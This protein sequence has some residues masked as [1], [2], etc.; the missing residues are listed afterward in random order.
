MSTYNPKRS[1]R[2]VRLVVALVLAATAAG[3]VYLYA[4]SMQR[5]VTQQQARPQPDASVAPTENPPVPVISVVVAHTDLQAKTPLG[6]DAFEL[7]EVPADRVATNAVKSL[8]AVSG[9]MLNAPLAAGEP[10][11][12]S[13]LVDSKSADIKTIADMIPTG[14][15]AMSLTLT[16]LDG[17]GGLIVPGQ[18]VD[19]VAVFTKD[20]LG[21][22]Q[23]MIM[24]QDI[25]VLAVAQSTSADQLVPVI[26]P[27]AAAARGNTRAAAPAAAA[28]P[29]LGATTRATPIPAA[30]AT[31]TQVAD[32]SA[33]APTDRLPAAPLQAKTVTVAVAPEAVERLALAK[34]HGHLSYVIR[35]TSERTQQS[36]LPADLG[37]LASPL[38]AAAAE[39]L[40][41]E[42]SPTN[43]KVGDTLTVK[44][45]IKNT[46]DKPLQ[47]MGPAPGFTYVQGQT[48]YTQQFASQP[49]KWRVAIGSAGLDSTELPYRWGLGADLA[50][51]AS[52]TVTGQIKLTAD[53]R[54]TNFWAAIVSE[55]AK[56]V[57]N[58]VGITLITAMPEN[59]AV[60]TVDSANARS[61]PSIA[62]SVI[63]QVP[64]GTELEIVGQSADWFK[65]KLPD[66]RVAWMAAGWIVVP[67]R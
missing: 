41:T 31:P 18:H 48:Y 19:V 30:T 51:G 49:G 37:T 5:Q 3:G 66:Q 4:S 9:K 11:T 32:S 67:G 50:P 60:V 27:T 16:E 56:I 1:R 40:A 63:D 58:G 21:K 44:I 36:L 8:E 25:L 2:G 65:V 39:I 46:S 26:T 20:T 57:Q 59:V 22:D 54:A 61:G 55:P 15:R 53:F 12:A 28:A 17:A 35:P 64:Y 43:V 38:E 7:R 14:L 42:I 34:D 29:A 47:T 13:R 62:S 33:L 10:L 52:T 24:L 45:T 23:S 6:S